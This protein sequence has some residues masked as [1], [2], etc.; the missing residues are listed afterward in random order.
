MLTASCGSLGT[1][2]KIH[3][4][5]DDHSRDHP[6]ATPSLDGIESLNCSCCEHTQLIEDHTQ[7]IEEHEGHMRE[8]EAEIDGLYARVKGERRELEQLREEFIEH[9]NAH[10]GLLQRYSEHFSAREAEMAQMYESLRAERGELRQLIIQNLQ[11][12]QKH[13]EL[14]QKHEARV[15]EAKRLLEQAKDLRQIRDAAAQQLDCLRGVFQTIWR[16]VDTR[17]VSA[18]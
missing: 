10:A 7:I 8:R 11:E 13:L 1:S 2:E 4:P 15:G 18:R 5:N 17:R 3:L 14:L 16:F 6:N 12:K 9:K